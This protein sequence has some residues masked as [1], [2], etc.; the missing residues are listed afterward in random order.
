[1]VFELR[2]L[3]ARLRARL[4]AVA[5][6]SLAPAM[7]AYM[8]SAM[9]FLGVPTPARRKTVAEILRGSTCETARELSELALLLWRQATHREDRARTA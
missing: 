5:D 9:S 8:K 1:M 4:E 6:P 2:E 3:A 7:K